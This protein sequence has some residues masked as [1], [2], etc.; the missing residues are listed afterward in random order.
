[1]FKRESC[2]SCWMAY[3]AAAAD[4]LRRLLTGKALCRAKDGIM[5]TQTLG[6]VGFS[7]STEQILSGS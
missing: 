7:L 4:R 2:D 3:K 6:H 1:M 5:Q